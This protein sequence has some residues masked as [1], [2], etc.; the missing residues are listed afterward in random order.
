VPLATA[1]FFLSLFA[2][3]VFASSGLLVADAVGFV[4]HR[5]FAAAKKLLH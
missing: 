1:T 2:S 5:S 4:A 3:T